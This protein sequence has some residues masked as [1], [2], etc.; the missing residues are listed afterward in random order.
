MLCKATWYLSH[1]KSENDTSILS[2]HWPHVW[3]VFPRLT[4]LHSNQILTFFMRTPISSTPILAKGC[5]EGQACK[6]T[7][8]FYA[9][10]PFILRLWSDAKFNNSILR[11]LTHSP[12]WRM[13]KK[14]QKHLGF[15]NGNCKTQWDAHQQH[16][17]QAFNQTI[18]FNAIC[19]E[20]MLF[21]GEVN[22]VW[23]GVWTR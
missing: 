21:E 6:V 4:R 7:S 8:T 22:E 2:A 1:L 14:I 5:R 20:I 3:V 13:D 18:I 10:F 12:W 19:L 11:L 16:R 9:A 23:N 15:I 17:Y